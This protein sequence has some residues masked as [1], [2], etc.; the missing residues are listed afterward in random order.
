MADLNSAIWQQEPGWLQKKRQLATLLRARFPQQDNQ[1]D[2]LGGW[3][4]EQPK[5][6][7]ATGLITHSGDYVVQPLSQAVN[8]Y[9]EMLQENLMEKAIF[10]QDGQLNAAHLARIDGGQFIYVPNETTLTAPIELAPTMDGENPH[11]VIILGAGS[12]VTIQETAQMTN[13]GA[14]YAGTELLVGNGATVTYRQFNRFAGKRALQAVHI[15]QAQGSHVHLEY[16]QAS[17]TDLTT[18]LYSFLDGQQTQWTADVALS[19]PGGAHYE[20]CPVLDG[21]GQGTAGHLHL[22]GQSAVPTELQLDHLKTGSGEPLAI[23]EQL[24]RLAPTNAIA[25]ALPAASWLKNKFEHA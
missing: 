11:N 25:D 15:Y 6:G 9:S 17:A 24:K 18:S 14:V 13:S 20:C 4:D 8:E 7:Q 3:K 22:W 23:T 19:V 21:Y 2:W 5:A 12:R 16:G 1:D 10:W